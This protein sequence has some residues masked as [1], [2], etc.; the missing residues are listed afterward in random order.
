ME[1]GSEYT[2]AAGLFHESFPT[3]PSA[4]IMTKD[5]PTLAQGATIAPRIL[6]PKGLTPDN[7]FNR[8]TCASETLLWRIIETTLRRR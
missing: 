1:S 2:L 3:C 7:E 5:D 4:S 6:V 8:Y